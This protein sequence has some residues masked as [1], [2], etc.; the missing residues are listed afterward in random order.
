MQVVMV[1]DK[2]EEAK[3]HVFKMMDDLVPPK[4]I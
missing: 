2:K 1:P 3:R 4:L